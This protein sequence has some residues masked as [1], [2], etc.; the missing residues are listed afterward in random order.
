MIYRP[1]G[2]LCEDI[3]HQ[4]N[5]E[6]WRTALGPD[7]CEIAS[8]AINQY[9]DDLLES[10]REKVIKAAWIVKSNWDDGPFEALYHA[11]GQSKEQSGMFAGLLVWMVLHERSERWMFYHDE[12]DC[13]KYSLWVEE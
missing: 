4:I 1:D 13:M 9:V 7:N 6:Q 3:P 12:D 2:V 8:R 5:W 11:C 10:D